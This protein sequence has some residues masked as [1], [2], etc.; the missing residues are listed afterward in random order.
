[1]SAKATVTMKCHDCGER[2]EWTIGHGIGKG[3]HVHHTLECSKCGYSVP[4]FALESYIR[5]GRA[6]VPK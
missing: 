3:G 1:M 5:T 2:T 4:D 6:I